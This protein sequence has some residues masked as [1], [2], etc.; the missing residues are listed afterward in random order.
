MIS[1]E[2]INNLI[3]INEFIH[4][5]EGAQ[6]SLI[7]EIRKAILDSGKL[8]LEEWKSL[9][10]GI[11]EIANLQSHIELIIKLKEEMHEE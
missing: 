9:K 11:V 10:E 8:S 4:K 6:N 7:S 2:D 1:Q 5:R 3:E